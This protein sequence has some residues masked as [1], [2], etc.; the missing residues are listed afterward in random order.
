MINQ[1]A[2]GVNLTGV[3]DS[4]HK[5]SYYLSLDFKAVNATDKEIRGD[6]LLPRTKIL[7]NHSILV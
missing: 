1:E 7:I 4:L 6:S 2:S 5:V 3:L